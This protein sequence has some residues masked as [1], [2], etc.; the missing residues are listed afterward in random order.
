MLEDAAAAGEDGELRDADAL[1][2][3]VH[4]ARSARARHDRGQRRRSAGARGRASARTTRSRAGVGAISSAADPPE[5]AAAG[6]GD[7]R[8]QRAFAS[9]LD[10]ATTPDRGRLAAAFATARELAATSR[11]GSTS[12]SRS[13]RSSLMA[14]LSWRIIRRTVRSLHAVSIGRRAARA[15]RV[16]RRDRA[17]SRATRSAIS[18]ARRTAPRADCASIASES[19]R[20]AWVK[21]GV[22]ELG[23]RIAG[24]LDPRTLGRKAMRVSARVHRRDAR[25]RSMSATTSRA[26]L[27]DVA[28]AD[29]VRVVATTIGVPLPHED[30][31]M[32]VL[33][34]DM[35]GVAD[36]RGDRSRQPRARLDRDRAARRRVAR[37]RARD[38][39]RDPASGDG[40]R[41]REQGARGVQ[42]LGVARPARAA[43]RDRRASARRSSRTRPRTC[44]AQGAGLPAADPRRRAADGRADRRP[45]RGC[46]ASVAA[47]SSASPSTCRR[48]SP[49]I[50]AEL[51]RDAPERTVEV[52]DP[53]GRRRRAPIRG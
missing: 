53:A 16:R 45:A 19:D 8:G 25:P 23:D 44:R 51:A 35:A 20:E 46:R 11:C 49:T 30:R 24:E 29:E 39:R 5:L 31:A 48:S 13:A 33:E 40:R 27:V 26:A 41:D 52:V 3:S 10:T 14:L 7:A 2:D 42:L 22:A 37:P 36:A 38:A 12:R 1:S 6:R 47:S 17:S 4:R 32:G 50:V 9:H 15:R 18:R 34:L 21:T 28:S 43:A